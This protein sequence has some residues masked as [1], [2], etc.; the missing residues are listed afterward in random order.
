M[1][2]LLISSVEHAHSYRAMRCFDQ[3]KRT[4]ITQATISAITPCLAFVFESIH[5]SLMIHIDGL[6]QDCSNSTANALELLQ[7]YTKP[8]IYALANWF[9]SSSGTGLYHV[10]C[11]ATC[12]KK[13]LGT[14]ILKFESKYNLFCP[15]N[16]IQTLTWSAKSSVIFSGLNMFIVFEIPWYWRW[17]C[18]LPYVPSSS[19]HLISGVK[20]QHVMLA[21]VERR[22]LLKSKYR[23]HA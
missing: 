17:K 2:F 7:S 16:A 14:K 6:V 3:V 8:S 22:Y 1:S 9:I 12:T 11:Q 18:T 20:I 23:W 5:R 21:M 13:F 19:T 10:L 15:V 4:A